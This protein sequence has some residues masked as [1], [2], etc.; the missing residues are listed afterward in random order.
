MPDDQPP[1]SAVIEDLAAARQRRATKTARSSHR[2]PLNDGV[3]LADFYAYMP[4]HN[5]IFAP[6]REMWPP[7]SIN[8]RLAP[9]DVGGEEIRASLWL[10]Q[11]SPVEQMTWGPGLPM[12]IENKLISDGGWIDRKGVRCF[13]LYRPPSIIPGDANQAGRWINHVKRVFPDDADHIIK[14]LAHRVQRPQDKINHALVLGGDQGIGKDTVLTPVKR[15]VG[16]WNFAEVSPQQMLGRFNG[17]V[18]SVILR[19]SEARDLGDSDRFKFYDHMKAY[20]AAPP[21]VLRVDEKHLREHAVL[22]CCGVIITTNHKTDG[23]YLPPDDRRHYVAWSDLKKEDFDDVYWKGLYDWYDAAGAGDVTA[24]LAALD[25]TEFN[26]KALPPKT[27]AFWEIVNASR[28]PEDAELIDVIERL[29]KPDPDT[30]GKIIQP[31]TVT[32]NELANKASQQFSEWL[33][34]RKN[35]RRIP[36][37]LEACG[38]VAVRNP[39]RTDGLWKVNHKSQVI[40]A[41]ATLPLRDRIAAAMK[42]AENP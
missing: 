40:Y 18:K 20:T 2:P 33:L 27:A 34:D 11:N 19:I 3:S 1:I 31:A 10:D 12:I 42:R 9:I 8:A 17:F 7:E 23:I 4:T 35:S 15:A 37:R 38:Y 22:N 5:Y 25:L 24:Y 6:T 36:H 21:D 41:R 28:P 26:S 39:A 13:N 14:W 16:P 29:G 32:L 30:L